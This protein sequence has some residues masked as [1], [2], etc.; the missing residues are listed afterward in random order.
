MQTTARSLILDLLS[1]LRRGSMPVR[2]LV[3]AGALLGL[4]ENNVRVSLARLCSSGRVERDERGRYRLGTAVA[5]IG[6]RLRDWRAL[7]ART[8]PWNGGWIAVH[9]A[10]LGRGPLR[11]RRERALDLLGFRELEPGLALRPDNLRGG[12]PPV[13]EQLVALATDERSKDCA[14]GRVFGL[15]G[16]DR[17]SETAARAL[18]DTDALT[19]EA[20]EAVGRLAESEG[21]LPTLTSEA[22]MV[23]S[24]RVGGAV[25]RQLMRHPLLPAEILD[26]APLKA[27]VRAMRHYDR[28]GRDHWARFLARH[29]VPHRALPLDAQAAHFGFEPLRSAVEP[30]SATSA[31]PTV[32]TPRP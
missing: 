21:R 18:W 27:L 13:R 19:R 9:S 6:A 24:F 20:R 29:D 7:D 28:I 26:P 17:E 3:E 15:R 32:E 11:R 10:R 5:A 16:L 25:L 22:A 14:L 12:L 8:G 23:E 1:T 31:P 30:L 4:E 2:A